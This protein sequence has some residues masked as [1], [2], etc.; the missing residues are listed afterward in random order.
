MERSGDRPGRPERGEH[1]RSEASTV[2]TARDPAVTV[3]SPELAASGSDGPAEVLEPGETIGRYVILNLLG[4]GGM[5]VVYTAY[6]PEL[7]RKVA[8][9]LLLTTDSDAGS[10][11]QREAQAMAKLS[12]PNVVTIHDVG[13]H[14]GQVY[15]AM[16]YVHGD[17]LDRW[18]RK[19]DPP[20]SKILELFLAAGEG[21]AAAHAAGLVHRDIKP[22]N[23][24]ISGD[25]RVRVMDFGLARAD[26]APPHN[27]T[28]KH[29]SLAHLSRS[30]VLNSALTMEGHLVGTPLYMAPEQWLGAPTDARSDIFS[31]AVALWE[32]LYGVHPFPSQSPAGVAVAVTEGE[33]HPPPPRSTVPPWLRR[34]VSRALATSPDD[35]WPSMR[36][37]VDALGQD[38]APRV[39]RLLL[40]GIALATTIAVI[41]S[42]RLDRSRQIRMCDQT[43][44]QISAIWS[45]AIAVEA[46]RAMLSTDV[47]FA[48]ASS[49]ST[50]AMLDTYADAWSSTRRDSCVAALTGETTPQLARRVDACL[51]DRRDTL[52]ALVLSLRSADSLTVEGSVNA[53]ASLQQPETCADPKR[54]GAYETV[55]E[56][57][58]EDARAL[59]QRLAAIRTLARTGRFDEATEAAAVAKVDAAQIRITLLEIRASMTAGD[60]AERRGDFPAARQEYAAALFAAGRSGADE[61]AAEATLALAWV[62]GVRLAEYDLGKAY[63]RLGEMWLERLDA[64][65][66][67]L[68]WHKYHHILGSL[69]DE[70]ADYEQAREHQEKAIAIAE[71]VLG[72]NHPLVSTSVNN[73]G[74]IFGSLG[75][76]NIAR[77][78]FRRALEIREAT[79]GPDHPEVAT[80]LAN[81]ANAETDLGNFDAAMELLQRSLEIRERSFGENHLEVASTLLNIARVT[82]SRGEFR[83]ALRDNERA[84]AIQERE[85]GP[86]HPRVTTNLFNVGVIKGELGDYAGGEA[87]LSQTLARQEATLTADHPRIGLTILALAEIAIERRDFAAAKALTLRAKPILAALG[88]QHPHYASALTVSGRALLGLGE[89][90]LAVAEQEQAIAIYR[91]KLGDAHPRLPDPLIGLAEAQL[92]VGYRE[93]AIDSAQRALIMIEENAGS[94]RVEARARFLLAKARWR[95]PTTRPQA[96]TLAREARGLAASAGPGA[97]AL[98]GDLDAWLEARGV[99]A[100]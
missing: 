15:L 75:D 47:R 77:E 52:E 13:T 45:P 46:Q 19:H 41:V 80:V 11:L 66:E 51:D 9:K 25:D 12:H 42:W 72:P 63:A 24:M 40:G 2:R 76:W 65:S 84:L 22:E 8:L 7:D 23:I 95:E 81:L 53:V 30:N 79:Y 68:R 21:I 37:F 49:T 54:L 27:L 28:G 74:L 20:W 90:A 92:E 14:G 32:G 97:A 56:E 48:D 36:A 61:L 67:D 62:S 34:V 10:R 1:P 59:H 89:G 73:L 64:P 87:A 60:V 88:A 33:L 26:Q 69:F 91:D 55:P 18:L 35:R 31:F 93:A 43:G 58:E 78:H 100:E 50:L 39:R 85:L 3:V 98:M 44:S 83:A 82:Y 16:E 4:H 86:D 57:L 99:A 70:Q 17:T 96:I 94:S 38:P 5:G 6:D 29:P 71:A